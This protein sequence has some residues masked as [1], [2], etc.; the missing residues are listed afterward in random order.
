VQVEARERVANS[1]RSR[2]RW[3]FL[4]V[5]LAAD[6]TALD[7]LHIFQPSPILCSQVANMAE[8]ELGAKK[9]AAIFVKAQQTQSK[10]REQRTERTEAN[11]RHTRLKYF[12]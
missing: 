1:N 11:S 5:H 2:A 6:K 4:G 10:V 8:A 12:L 9:L 7:A 3:N